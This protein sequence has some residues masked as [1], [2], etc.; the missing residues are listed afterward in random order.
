MFNIQ[1]RHHKPA[2]P[3]AYCRL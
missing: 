1:G 2:E 3:T